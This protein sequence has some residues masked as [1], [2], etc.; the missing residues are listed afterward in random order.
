MDLNGKRA[1]VTGATGGL[2]PAIARA[3]HAEGATVLVTGRRAELLDELTSELGGRAEALPADLQS[4][5]HVAGLAERAGS[6]DVLV[7]NAGVPGTGA[8]GEYETE[9]I[10]RVIDVNLRSVIH[11]THALLPA[12]LERD[13]GHL[14]YIS[15][16]SGKIAS[17]RA[18]L[19]N[20]TKFGLRGFSLSLH[21]ELRKTGV[22]CTTIFPGFIEDAGMWADSQITA[23]AGAGARKP[24]DVAR[25]VLRAIAK[26][27]REIDVAGVLPRSGGW[28]LGI[29]PGLVS[30]LQ[31]MGGG[32][33]TTAEL[34]EAQKV[35]R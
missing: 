3:L 18:S 2:G 32:D 21:D 16:I 14:V 31:R 9:Q 10:D 6:V 8:L 23:P 19:Y 20:A 17:P 15:S 34:A 29:A 28:L 27:P 26:N 13:S 1:L 25:A 4:A 35:K 33:R 24:D 22:G 11:L 5:E 30:A 12:M 7:A